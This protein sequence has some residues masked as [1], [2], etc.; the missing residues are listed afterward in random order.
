MPRFFFNLTSHGN[1]T[2]DETGT[3]FPSLEAAYIDTC[4]AI[5]DIAFEKLRA[6]QDPA[7]DS[8]EITDEQR[9]VL[10]LVPFCEVLL[11]AA[12]K[13][14]P[15]RLKTIQL[16]DNCRDQF[17]RSAALQADMRA[18]FQQARKTFSDIRANLARIASHTSG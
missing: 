12:A 1:V 10:M 7:T 8:F 4:Q 9:S 5:L 15:V 13:N 3:E 18:E 11:P 6:R 16:L 14:R 17:A 2:L